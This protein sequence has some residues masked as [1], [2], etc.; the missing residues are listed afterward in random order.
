MKFDVVA[1][2]ELLI[3][4]TEHGI[5]EQGNPLWEANP[6]G[7]PC[8][9]L[10]M[11]SKLGRR[12]AFIGK[13][14]DDVYGRQLADAVCECGIDTSGLLFDK[15]V[16]TTLAI[17]HKKPNGDRDFGFYRDPGADVMLRLHEVP[18]KLVDNARIF[19]FGTLSMTHDGAREAT[20]Y[21]VLRAK[22]NGALISFDPNLRQPLWKSEASMLDQMKWGLGVCDILK[23]SDDEISLITGESDPELA[24]KKLSKMYP[25]IR[26]MCV[27][28]GINGSYCPRADKTVFVPSFKLDETI[29][30]TGAGDAF[31]ACMLNFVLGKGIDRI[32]D[33]DVSEMMRFASAAAA[34]IT[35]K[36]GAL[37]VMPDIA[38]IKAL[39]EK[40]A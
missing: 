6:G 27:T 13:V 28:A 17:V 15:S 23:I 40:Q 37:R 30:T 25:Q 16:H 26:I 4:F 34:L 35:T 32:S 21:S 33:G 38:D 2:G 3:D 31:C 10:S 22:E 36:K 24:A 1:I 19:H 8:N 12:V 14:G 39:L 5:S 20:K 18:A 29:E 11:L 9:V 7:A